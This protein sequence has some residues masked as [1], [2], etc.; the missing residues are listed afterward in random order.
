VAALTVSCGSN[1]PPGGPGPTSSGSVT[2][3]DG[4]SGFGY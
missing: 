4:T 2:T 1:Q 3:D